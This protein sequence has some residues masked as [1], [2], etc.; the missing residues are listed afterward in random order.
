M[1]KRNGIPEGMVVL[2][3]PY[4]QAKLAE[5]VRQVLDNFPKAT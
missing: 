1:S 4:R 2:E 5:V 3:K